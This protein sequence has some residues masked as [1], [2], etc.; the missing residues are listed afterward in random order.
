MGLLATSLTVGFMNAFMGVL[1]MACGK[2]VPEESRV[3]FKGLIWLLAILGMII[4]LCLCFAETLN[5]D[6]SSL[7]LNKGW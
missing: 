2:I 1:F 3:R 6:L 4:F 7:Y 5:R